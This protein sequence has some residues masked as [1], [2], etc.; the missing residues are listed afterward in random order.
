MKTAHGDNSYVKQRYKAFR[1]V[2]PSTDFGPTENSVT[3]D[4]TA[5]VEW[6]SC[7]PHTCDEIHELIEF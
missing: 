3:T 7:Q 4:L 5:K 1:Q 2:G 6:S